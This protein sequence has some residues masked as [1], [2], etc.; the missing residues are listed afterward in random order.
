MKPVRETALPEPAEFERDIRAAYEPVVIRGAVKGW[1]LLDSGRRSPAEGLAYLEGLDSGAPTEL[2]VAPASERGRFF[3]SPDMRGFNFR[4]ERASLSQL[5]RHLR[6]IEREAEPIGIYAGA[7]PAVSHL[8]GFERENT[9]PLAQAQP[10]STTRVWVGN[11]TQVATHFDLSDNFAVV[12]VGKRRFTLF[13]PEATENLYVGPLDMTL[14]GQP[15]SMVD[16]LKPDHDRYPRFEKAAALAQTAE[17][18]P[19]D[20][21]YI[22]TL[23]WHHVQA[24]EAINVLVNYWHNDARRGGGFLAL[25]HAILAIRDQPE[26]QRKAWRSWF[27][28]FVFADDAA[29]AAAHLPPEA[30]TVTGPP[31]PQRD[32]MIRHFILQVLSGR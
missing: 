29:E 11:A 19:G 26:G 32:D 10:G 24:T 8:P 23:W 22:P 1:P 27:D 14:A 31:S 18:G 7:T 30:R 20:A 5:T 13:P 16:P 17:L 21:I 3:Y 2:M 6:E 15:V 28:H 12:A 9:F 25:V 4:R